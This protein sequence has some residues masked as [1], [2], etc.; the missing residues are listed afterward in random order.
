M[1]P[2]A[3]FSHSTTVWNQASALTDTSNSIESIFSKDLKHFWKKNFENPLVP[4]IKELFNRYIENSVRIANEFNI[5]EDKSKKRAMDPDYWN[6]RHGLFF[7]NWP[8]YSFSEDARGVWNGCEQGMFWFPREDRKDIDDILL[9]NTRIGSGN[10]C[11]LYK[12][13]VECIQKHLSKFFSRE[14]I[15]NHPEK[16]FADN[17]TNISFDEGSFEMPSEI[18]PLNWT[19]NYFA[20]KKVSPDFLRELKSGLDQLTECERKAYLKETLGFSF[21]VGGAAT[22]LLFAGCAGILH[23]FLAKKKMSAESQLTEVI[24]KNYGS[25]NN[26]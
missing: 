11:L 3:P 25:F 9:L 10:T 18:L 6:Y 23:F 5:S 15:Y 20:T 22:F 26:Q 24:V 19:I 12:E 17:S 16:L 4:S 21:L 14:G 1:H 2:L 13:Q 8:P 7:T